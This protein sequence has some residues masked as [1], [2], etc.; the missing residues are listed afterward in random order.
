MIINERRSDVPAVSQPDL[1]VSS[2]GSCAKPSGRSAGRIACGGA[3]THLRKMPVLF[4]NN[5]NALQNVDEN[6]IDP[7]GSALRRTTGAETVETP[8][9]SIAPVAEFLRQGSLQSLVLS[10]LV[11]SYC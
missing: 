3:A 6:D 10:L 4:P 7:N 8:K 1:Q 11:V 5:H 2:A 9:W